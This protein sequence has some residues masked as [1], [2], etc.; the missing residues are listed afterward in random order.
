MILHRKKI[1]MIGIGA[2]T[3]I[4]IAVVTT[5]VLADH[6]TGFS[7]QGISLGVFGPLDVKSEK[8][9]KWKLSIKSHG[10]TDV[11]VTRVRWGPLASS[12]WHSHPGPNLLTVVSGSVREWHGNDPLCSFED[13]NAGDTFW[14]NGGSS[15]HLVRNLSTT[16][17]AE[18]IAV[19]FYPHATG[20]P[21]SPAP[22]TPRTRP[23]NCTAVGAPVN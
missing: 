3:A 2:A 16:D 23:T 10:Q 14:D 6:V 18:V 13:Y 7:P 5:P 12:N 17:H 4:A 8:D 11:R 15:I 20:S 1:A 19:A 21:P 9:D 22:T